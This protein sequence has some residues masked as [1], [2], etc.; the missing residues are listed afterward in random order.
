M[1]V[2]SRE[3][4]SRFVVAERSFGFGEEIL[5]EEA[6]FH[7]AG[8][9]ARA[10]ILAIPAFEKCADQSF[11]EHFA[12]PARL[13]DCSFED[14]NPIGPDSKDVVRV[15]KD[16]LEASGVASRR[17]RV[18]LALAL[19]ANAH[20]TRSG[21]GLF[22][23]GAM[24]EHCCLS[25]NVRTRTGGS[26]T[27]RVWFAG[28]DIAAGEELEACYID[29]SSPVLLTG[30]RHRQRFLAATK[31]FDCRCRDC[32][33]E[34]EELCSVCQRPFAVGEICG[35]CGASTSVGA[36][37]LRDHED[38]LF[39]LLVGG[40]LAGLPDE[41][42]LELLLRTRERFGPL[43]WAESALALALMHDRP[44]VFDSIGP[45][46]VPLV[47]FRQDGARRLARVALEQTKLQLE[48][49]VNPQY[50]GAALGSLHVL[51]QLL[52]RCQTDRAFREEREVVDSAELSKVV[53]KTL[54]FA[55]DP[56]NREACC[57]ACAMAAA[58][59][60]AVE[61]DWGNDD[62]AQFVSDEQEDFEVA[63]DYEDIIL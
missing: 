44:T 4:G 47:M 63:E 31:L 36:S 37:V 40:K 39:E 30:A 21:T 60:V 51:L 27:S 2:V 28:R 43:H 23:L 33:R 18:T 55:A 19:V 25:G 50:R 14:S 61:A 53:A 7:F 11:L 1:R 17:A 5:H 41:Q 12:V 42:A 20:P 10:S 49:V 46:T 58:N 9:L 45:T 24:F 62:Q 35:A 29:Q 32:R 26:P 34:T 6:C 8:P 15:V 48:R 22:R 59:K 16:L 38:R 54:Y 3:D 13:L 56:S 57:V 52:Q